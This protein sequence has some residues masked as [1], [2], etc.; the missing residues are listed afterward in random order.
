ML[1]NTWKMDWIFRNR[2]Y[3]VHKNWIIIPFWAERNERRWKAKQKNDVSEVRPAALILLCNSRTSK[4]AGFFAVDSILDPDHSQSQVSLDI[5]KQKASWPVT[6]IREPFV[7]SP[8]TSATRFVKNL[9][10][11]IVSLSLTKWCIPVWTGMPTEAWQKS[12]RIMSSGSK[13][14]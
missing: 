5:V 1:K 7:K 13:I 9:A 6:L 12:I 11:P 14:P 8:W 4:A 2:C 3:N 10:S